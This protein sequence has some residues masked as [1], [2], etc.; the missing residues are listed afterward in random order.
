MPFKRRTCIVRADI[1]QPPNT[2]GLASMQDVLLRI[3]TGKVRLRARHGSIDLVMPH[4][5]IH[6]IK[7]ILA[8]G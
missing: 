6:R 5:R 2:L 3:A 7:I 1:Y 4:R 8:E